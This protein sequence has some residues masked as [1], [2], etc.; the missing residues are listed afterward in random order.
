MAG[1]MSRHTVSRRNFLASVAVA[2][3]ATAATDLNN[4][5][6]AT[7]PAATSA[8]EKPSALRPSAKVAAAETGVPEAPAHAAGTPTSDFMVDVIKTLDIDYVASNPAASFRSL[9]ELLINYGGNRKP[10]WLTCLHEEFAVAMAHGYAKAAGKPMAAMVHSTVGLQHASMALYNAWCDRVPVILFTGNTMNAATR[11]PGTEWNHAAQDPAAMVRDFTRF[12]DQ[13]AS[14]QQFAESTVRAY[15]LA[16][17]PPMAP[18]VVTVDSDLQEN[19]IHNAELLSIPKLTRAA[20]PHADPDA[21]REAAKLLVA[22]ERPLIVADRMART[23]AGI[24]RLVELAEALNAPVIDAGS[25]TNF[26]TTHQL[27]LSDGRG[28][29]VGQAD[30]ILLLEVTNAWGV[31]QSVAEKNRE[32]ALRTARKD[33]KLIHITLGDFLMKSNYQDMQRYQAIDLAIT[34]DAEA[35]LPSLTEAVRRELTGERKSALAARGET[36]RK[37]HQ[38]MRDRAKTAASYGWSTRVRSPRRG[39]PPRCGRR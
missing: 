20:A 13:P 12:D 10:E 37:Q 17:T 18:V 31:L 1:K 16:V 9:H 26:P 32:V 39:S 19:R 27:N 6:A 24:D 7:S 33:V 14:L 11:K 38:E 35:S 22:A 2:G 29:L 3:A 21:L 4:K 8:A 28:S 36:L 25:R 34:G 23:Q 30:V 5:A 15:K